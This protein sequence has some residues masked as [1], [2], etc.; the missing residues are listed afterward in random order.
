MQRTTKVLALNEKK[1]VK[2][3]GWPL[4]GR[5]LYFETKIPFLSK[6]KNYRTNFD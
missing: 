6:V 2:Q 5:N 3:L 4:L 1:N